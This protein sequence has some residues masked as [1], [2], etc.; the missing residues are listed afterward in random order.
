M[1]YPVMKLHTSLGLKFGTRVWNW[2][3]VYDIL[4][5]GYEISYPGVKPGLEF[6]GEIDQSSRSYKIFNP[7]LTG[8][9]TQANFWIILCCRRIVGKDCQNEQASQV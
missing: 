9:E 1:S 8:E 7:F 3:F 4:W 5:R 2:F 6:A